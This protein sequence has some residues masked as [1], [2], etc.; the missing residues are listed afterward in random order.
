MSSRVTVSIRKAAWL[1]AGS[2]VAWA[3]QARAQ[4]PA[5]ATD[6]EPSAKSPPPAAVGARASRAA[7]P[8]MSELE[9]V[10]ALVE[11]NPNLHVALLQEARARA[12]V[13]GEESLYVPVLSANAGVTQSRSPS[14]ARGGAISFSSGNTVDVGAGVSK[15]LPY[16]TAF[17]LNLTGQRSIRTSPVSAASPTT[18]TVGPAYAAAAKLWITQPFLRGA[19]LD[20]GQASLRQARLNR[21]AAVLEA[22]Q[23][24]SQLLQDG[25]LAYWELWYGDETVRI[26]QASRDLAVEQERQALEQV[27]S[28]SIA[29]S[30]ALPYRTRHAELEESVV[31]STTDRLS[32][33]IALA[34]TLGQPER[35][36]SDLKAAGPLPEKVEAT[37][38]SPRAVADALGN[39]FELKQIETQIA[40]AQDQAKI[41]GDA[42]RPR[43]DGEAYVQAQGLGYREV[44]PA[45]DQIGRMQA[46]SAHV[47]LTFETPLTDTRREAQRQ[48]ANL[49]VHIG[50]K[51]LEATRQQIKAGIMT[52]VANR[53]AALRKVKFAEE[54]EAVARE[55]T[56]ASKARFSAGASVALEIRQA[57]DS[58]RQ[59]QLRLQRAKVDL[60]EADIKLLHLRGRLLDRYTAALE[61]LRPH[62]SG[63]PADVGWGPW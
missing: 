44:P 57:E 51:Q 23:I 12:T 2:V 24:A 56:E 22:Q 60:I 6:D 33:A 10:Q 34:Q 36:G 43:L 47:G 59:A 7:T 20:I 13:R 19:G 9:A 62:T 42:L 38:S 26:D 55:Q 16:G 50:Y 29:K 48:N 11:H 25:L 61:R 32:R 54:T 49:T 5:A 4:A 41:A 8:G 63:L 45:F 17:G 53:E 3:G 58:W 27:A 46:L 14:M 35:G 52:A 31:A 30:E 21:T 37:P 39:S 28:G 15:S 1:F 18:L 40:I